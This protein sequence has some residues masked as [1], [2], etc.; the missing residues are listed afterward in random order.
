MVN[1]FLI[2]ACRSPMLDPV[3]N[4]PLLILSDLLGD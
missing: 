2:F 4:L 3:I 1:L